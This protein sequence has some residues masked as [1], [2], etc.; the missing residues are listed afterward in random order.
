MIV[1]VLVQLSHQS[2][3][4]ILLHYSR[5]VKVR[6]KLE[7]SVEDIYTDAKSKC[8]GPCIVFVTAYPTS[9]VSTAIPLTLCSTMLWSICE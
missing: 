6:S 4:H 5:F 2:V 8:S 3:P 7:D 1:I 9:K